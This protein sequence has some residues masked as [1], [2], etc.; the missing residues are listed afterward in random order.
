MYHQASINLCCF[1]LGSA[2]GQSVQIPE[3]T[4]PPHVSDLNVQVLLPVMSSICSDSEKQT[5]VSL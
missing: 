2:Q 5:T 3:L 1:L 4:D